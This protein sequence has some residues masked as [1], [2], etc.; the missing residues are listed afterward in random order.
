MQIFVK[1]LTGKTITLEVEGSDT[2]EN[3]K[4][5]IQDKEGACLA[6]APPSRPARPSPRA[7]RDCGRTAP[8]PRLVR[9]RTSL[10]VS[11][12]MP[13]L[14]PRAA[15]CGEC[16][17]LC[18]F[19]SSRTS[20]HWGASARSRVLE[21]RAEV[22]GRVLGYSYSGID[23]DRHQLANMRRAFCHRHLRL[24]RV[25]FVSLPSAHRCIR[26]VCVELELTGW[27][28]GK[29]KNSQRTDANFW[30]KRAAHSSPA[31]GAQ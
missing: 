15:E 14:Q 26:H 7:R 29:T 8:S 31:C 25:V 1:T 2:I 27:V 3:V 23:R 12:S 6:R 19:L 30:G 13:A 18:F 17:L 10:R 11:A 4:A 20:M 16:C 21:C 28:G 22:V 24:R 5:K 9:A